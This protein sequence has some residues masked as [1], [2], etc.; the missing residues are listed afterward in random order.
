MEAVIVIEYWSTVVW[1]WRSFSA[2]MATIIKC[3]PFTLCEVPLNCLTILP[4][5]G[6]I[7]CIII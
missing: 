3:M 7:I 6:N 5:R 4:I 1:D 2:N